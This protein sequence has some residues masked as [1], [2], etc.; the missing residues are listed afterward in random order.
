MSKPHLSWLLL[1]LFSSPLFADDWPQWQGPERNAISKETGLMQQWPEGGPPLAW[2]VDGLG[3][4]DS[5]PSV[6]DGKLFGM[7]NR[8]G[9]QIVW[10]RSETDGQEIWSTPLGDAVDQGPRQ[11]KEGPGCTPSV[12]GDRLY[13]IGM[14]GTV[15][16]LRVGDGEIVWRRSFTEDFGGSLPMW[17]YRESPLV[18]GDKVI[19]TPGSSDAL[20]VALDKL[21]GTTVWKSQNPEASEESSSE[22]SRG[23][24]PQS[25]GD[26]S[27]GRSDSTPQITGTDVPDLF[28][29][30]HWGM[31]AFSQKVPN[32]KYL[33]KLYFAETYNGIR[34]EGQR[35]FSF[36]V[37]GKD[38]KDFDIWKKAGG[39]RKAYV[40][41]VPAEVTDG[42]LDITFT[43]QAENPAIKAIEIIPQGDNA[44][45]EETIRIKAGETS[46]FKDSKGRTW[47]A[48][49]GFTG[50][51]TSPGVFNFGGGRPGGFGVRRGG[52]GGRGGGRSGAAY[53][54]VIAIDFEGQKQYVQLTAT[55]LVGVSAT[56]GTV[57][58]QYKAPANA[59]GINCSTPIFQDGL[60]FAA[61]AYGTGGGAVKL[62]K[63]D[64]GSID[65]TE[66]YFT[67]RMQNHHGGMIATGDALYGANGGNG[68]GMMTCIDFQT[69]NLLWRD[70]KGPKGA[71]LLADGRIYLRGE[72]GEVLLIEPS[73]EGLVEK[74]RFDQPDRSSSPAWAHPIVANGKL[75][76]RDQDLL[77]CYDVT[78]R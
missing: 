40:E 19:C 67:N 46:P 12:D 1:S 15:A 9:K 58:W 61:S 11:S 49:R 32:G 51:A 60:V 5:A 66:V 21:D 33:T 31:T 27:R 39:P 59:M 24:E 45:D 64:D 29:S 75:Y 28:L 44:K 41:S 63:K 57:L 65:A 10:A 35:V 2:R 26:L 47:L 37:E 53:S 73:R 54:S 69:G 17:S 36:N 8:D 55:S 74:G 14:G 7:S 50:G 76:I 77:F 25:E 62:A 3:G 56:D 70:R 18:D 43:R 42:Q 13:V 48:E 20:I 38:F 6:A 78:A 16:C 34:G 22:N 30:E 68:G 4:G 23:R 71:L 72:D 52:F